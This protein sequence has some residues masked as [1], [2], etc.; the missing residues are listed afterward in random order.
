MEGVPQDLRGPGGNSGFAI[1]SGDIGSEYGAVGGTGG[2]GGGGLL[3]VA[4]G[5]AFV[6]EG[7]INLSGSDGALAP[8]TFAQATGESNVNLYPG[9]GQGGHPG[10]LYIALVGANPLLPVITET[11]FKAYQGISP[12]AGAANKPSPFDFESYRNLPFGSHVVFDGQG[13]VS[14]H[15]PE[16]NFW[17]SSYRIVQLGETE[18]TGEIDRA[19]GKPLSVI[20]TESDTEPPYVVLEVSV[21]PPG[22]N[23]YETAEIFY[24][25]STQTKYTFLGYAAPE[26]LLEVQAD[27]TQYDFRVYAVSKYDE[28]NEDYLDYSFTVSNIA[29]PNAVA[30][31]AN[32]T[33]DGSETN[34]ITG[35][36]GQPI[37]RALA[38]WDI[39]PDPYIKGYELEFKATSETEWKSLGLIP[40][41]VKTAWITPVESGAN[42][43][44]RIRGTKGR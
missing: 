23:N 10:A 21:T 16:T 25:R 31:P 18:P 36:S 13:D 2:D 8:Q 27:G 35:P 1:V 37:A 43:D 19:T 24:K 38:S 9:A 32:F 29:D 33:V 7:K 11:N 20:V 15:V 34:M 6:G 14:E 41:T 39:V 17:Q 26:A 42:M 12:L 5:V 44:F 4:K 22:D 28:R 3:I 30:V 40:P